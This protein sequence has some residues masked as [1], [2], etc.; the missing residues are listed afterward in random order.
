MVSDSAASRKSEVGIAL[1]LAVSTGT[2]MNDFLRV[3]NQVPPG[4]N[5]T[6]KDMIRLVALIYAE[7]LWRFEINIVVGDRDQNITARRQ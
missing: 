2:S 7:E 4:G 3:S 5:I 6:W 1:P